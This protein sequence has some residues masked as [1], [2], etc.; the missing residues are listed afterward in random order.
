MDLAAKIY[1]INSI[2]PKSIA[3]KTKLL[4]RIPIYLP[5]L[6]IPGLFSELKRPK[7]PLQRTAVKKPPPNT[8]TTKKETNRNREGSD[9]QVDKRLIH[10]RKRSLSRTNT[11]PKIPST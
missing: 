11:T 3:V 6:S 1:P 5:A 10:A 9:Q 7:N 8:I 2:L 4:S